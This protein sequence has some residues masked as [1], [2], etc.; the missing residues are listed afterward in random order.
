MSSPNTTQTNKACPVVAKSFDLL[1][2]ELPTIGARRVKICPSHAVS[3]G[4]FC[5]SSAF[6]R[7]QLSDESKRKRP[8]LPF[9]VVFSNPMMVIDCIRDRFE[10]FL[11]KKYMYRKGP[12]SGHT[13]YD[14]LN[15]DFH[16]WSQK[17]NSQCT[18]NHHNLTSDSVHE[19][20]AKGCEHFLAL[21][22]VTQT[23]LFLCTLN[24]SCESNMTETSTR[25]LVKAISE[26]FPHSHVLFVNIQVDKNLPRKSKT[27]R[28]VVNTVTVTHLTVRTPSKSNGLQLVDHG[29]NTFLE[30]QILALYDFCETH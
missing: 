8:M 1:Y 21:S 3:I 26:M 9:D 25:K 18:F 15:A 11:C 4:F 27:T 23:K 16:C 29:D 30:D 12:K 13:A 28:K 14:Q 20:Y 7:R 10:K 19:K 5:Q 17:R 24:P 22:K 2:I 6:I